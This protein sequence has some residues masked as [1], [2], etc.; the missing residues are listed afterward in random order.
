[1]NDHLTKN[2]NDCAGLQVPFPLKVLIT[3]Q[4]MVVFEMWLVHFFSVF[5][6]NS[7]NDCSGFMII[8][9]LLVTV[10]YPLHLRI[11]ISVFSH[12]IQCQNFKSAIR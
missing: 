10:M 6:P 12:F 1:M 3:T 7:S 8:T 9:Y 4:C 5:I 11:F 2:H